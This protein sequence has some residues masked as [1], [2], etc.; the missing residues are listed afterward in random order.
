VK[1]GADADSNLVG[2]RAQRQAGDG[3]P[4]TGSAQNQRG[5][6]PAAAG[7]AGRRYPFLLLVMPPRC[8]GVA[9]APRF[10]LNHPF[11]PILVVFASGF[12]I[13][14]AWDGK[15]GSRDLFFVC[16]HCVAGRSSPKTWL[17]HPCQEQSCPA[18]FASA[19]CCIG[20]LGRRARRSSEIPPGPTPNVRPQPAR[21]PDCFVILPAG[22]ITG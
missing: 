9:L 6:V 8:L 13:L 20:G 22:R 21:W 4:K 16:G 17:N 15:K 12:L 1:T 19:S 10:C 5:K 14:R 7:S 18:L 11:F 3:R 2:D